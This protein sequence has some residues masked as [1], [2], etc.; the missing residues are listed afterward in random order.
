M[1]PT[2]HDHVALV[3]GAGRGIGRAI[4]LRLAHAGC[5]VAA[6]AR[7]AERTRRDRAGRAGGGGSGAELL[8]VPADVTCDGDLETAARLIIERLGRITVLVNNAGFAPPRSCVLKTSLADWD[9][10]LGTCLRAPMVLTRLVLPDML[11][12]GRGAIVNIASIAGKRGA[13]RRSRLRGRQVRPAGLHAVALRRGARPRHQGRRDLPRP[14]GHRPDSPQQARRPRQVPAAARRR[15]GRVPACSPVRCAPARPRSCSSRSTMPRPDARREPARG[16]A[17]RDGADHRRRASARA[18]DRAQPGRRRCDV[19]LPTSPP[20]P[21]HGHRARPRV[22]RRAR[23]GRAGRCRPTTPRWHAPSRGWPPPSPQLDLWVANAG[24]FR[25]TPLA[26]LREPTGTTC[27]GS[28][29]QRSSSR[30]AASARSCSARAAAAS[31]R[32]PT[33]PRCAL[34]PTTSPTASPSAPSSP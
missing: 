34:G 6:L 16:P 20:P 32:S 19:A 10:T 22:A 4:V 11:A 18:R 24:V 23:P 31:S 17:R 5:R 3:T 8:A 26:R 9:R 2:L 25:R 28:T 13:R 15:R 29:S 33:S 1:R 14:R 27:C 12:H 7:T 21:R 30:R